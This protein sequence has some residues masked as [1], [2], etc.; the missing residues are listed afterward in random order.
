[1]NVDFFDRSVHDVARDLIGCTLLYEDVGGVI[2][3]TESYAEDDPACHAY[4]GPTERSRV[5]FGPPGRT[6]VYFTYGMHNLLNFVAEPDG[7]AGAVLIRSLEP[8]VG[9]DRMCTRRKLERLENL[10]SGPAKLT[11]ALGIDLTHN[12]QPIGKNGIRVMPRRG[13]WLNA[14]ILTGSR[15]GISRA[16]D[17]PWRYC[18]AGSRFV[19]KPLATAQ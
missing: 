9:I 3:E 10:C 1:M 2:V 17:R 5:L 18:A 15:I 12:D 19:S 11:Q 6:Y 14:E 13:E 8:T 4:N 16:T 7:T